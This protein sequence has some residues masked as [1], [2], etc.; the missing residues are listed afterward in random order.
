[1]QQAANF[2]PRDRE[3][4]DGELRYIHLFSLLYFLWARTAPQSNAANL[5]VSRAPISAKVDPLAA[6]TYPPMNR[7]FFQCLT[8]V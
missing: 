2:C 3:L 8:A 6:F 4:R 7:R 1:M 5:S